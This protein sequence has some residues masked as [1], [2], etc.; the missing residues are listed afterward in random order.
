[1]TKDAYFEMCEALGSEP[2]N[3]EV[4]VEYDELATEV[5]EAL[6]IYNNLQDSWD[7]FGGNYV[8]KIGNYGDIFDIYE[9]PKEDRRT[10][11][12]FIMSIDSIR[13]KSIRDSKPKK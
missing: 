12:E 3:S 6:R 7:Y 13:A 2:L 4:P 1:M 11:Y 5:Q 9:V 8:G 10:L